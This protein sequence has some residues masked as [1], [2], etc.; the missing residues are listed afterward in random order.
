MESKIET[1]YTISEENL[2]RQHLLAEMLNPLSLR[3]L[4]QI[5][6][7]ANAKILDVGCGLGDTT[8]ML[9]KHFKDTK[10]TGVDANASLIAHAGQNAYRE[11]AEFLLSDARQLPFDDDIFD[12]V[13][14]SYVTHH[15]ADAP[16]AIR[17]MR[18]V[19]KPG[20]IVYD[21]EPDINFCQTYPE[22]WAYPK[23]KE[24]MTSLFAD[25]NLGRK[26][27][28]YFRSSGFE[29]IHSHIQIPFDDRS[30]TLKKFYTMTA[31]AMREMILKKKLMTE[32]KLDKLIL[33]MERLRDDP[34]T[35]LLIYP[36][37]AVWGRKA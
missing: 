6:L 35:I 9:A 37:I 19:C 18:R 31:V 23:M 3:S 11:E 36:S 33:E 16:S 21:Q 8:I 10:V 7:P 29:N 34:D 25:A 14:S 4:Q 20:G 26:L 17:E 22:S 12:M 5:K 24:L 1:S 2:E 28:H 32:N 13:F 15:L 27:V 30:V